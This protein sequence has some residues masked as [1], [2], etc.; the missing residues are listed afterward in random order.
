MLPSLPKVNILLVDDRPEN[1]I[2]L[3]A[4]LEAP[5]YEL[6]Q[7]TSG[8]EALR[9]L[10]DREFAL[11]LMDVQMPG[12]DG[13]ETARLIKSREKT[14]DIPIIFVTAISKDEPFVFRGYGAGAVDYVTKPFDPH[15][16]RSKVAVFADLYRKSVLLKEQ[17]VARVELQAL[18]RENI[19]NQKYRDLVEDIHNGFVWIADPESLQFTFVSSRSSD[20]LGYSPAD[21]ISDHRFWSICSHPE[22]LES[23]EYALR[24]GFSAERTEQS[25]EHRMVERDGKTL[26]FQ[27]S[28]RLTKHESGDKFEIRG[29]SINV[30][31]LKEAEK[32]ARLAVQA[33]DEFL[34]IASHELKTPLTALKLQLNMYKVLSRRGLPAEAFIAKTNKLFEQSSNQVDRLSRLVEELLDV[35]Q[36][37]NGKLN[38]HFES[39]DLCE[40]LKEV[41]AR[42]GDD[43]A[44]CQV[45]VSLEEGASVTGSWDRLRIDQVI[46]N[47]IT[48]AIKY[49]DSKPVQASLSREE[50]EAVIRVKDQGIGISEEDQSRIFGRFERAVSASNFG[51]LGL[52]LYIVRQIVHEHGGSVSVQSKKNEGS[53]F[54]VR[55]PLSG[56][57]SAAGLKHQEPAQLASK[58]MDVSLH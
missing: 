31:H 42:Y 8:E 26:W 23:V 7:A 39:F 20:L 24:E 19:I 18:K 3:T 49:G 55:L 12:M 25:F 58:K 22:D 54:T 5:G 41:C 28:A 21:W 33:R 46:T 45:D 29:L 15:I 56:A 47:L 11:I 37:N 30:T 13:F 36:I 10:L 32:E 6:A 50:Q 38:L 16:L 34:S 44:K 35:S 9:F 57:L 1:L 14:R 27:T 40:L 4:V 2:S 52:G 51:G 43:A 17:E 48:N 53:T